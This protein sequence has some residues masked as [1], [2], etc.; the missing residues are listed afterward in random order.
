MCPPPPKVPPSPWTTAPSPC[1]YLLA[2]C[3]A[4]RP[5]A[6]FDFVILFKCSDSQAR[7]I[8]GHAGAAPVLTSAYPPHTQVR[9]GVIFFQEVNPA[10]ARLVHEARPCWPRLDVVLWCRASL[11]AAGA[12]S[13]GRGPP[14][15]RPL[16]PPSC[17][18]TTHAAH[19]GGPGG[20]GLPA[21]WHRCALEPPLTLPHHAVHDQPGA[22]WEKVEK[23]VGHVGRQAT[24]CT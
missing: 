17:P 22:Y 2:R 1:R 18:K 11:C 23:V 21:S 4:R 5:G 8:A 7:S 13:R 19:A 9:L 20:D 15:A 14:P 16:P 12:P 24:H 3:A 10:L 6:T